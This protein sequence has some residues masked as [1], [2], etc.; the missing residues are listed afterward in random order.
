MRRKQYGDIAPVPGA[1]LLVPG[2]CGRQ[3][4]PGAQTR[5]SSAQPRHNYGVPTLGRV[6]S[7]RFFFF[8]NEGDEPP[9]VHVSEGNKLAKFWLEDGLVAKSKGFAQHELNEMQ[10]IV[11]A[12]RDEFLGEWNGFFGKA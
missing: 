1:Q 4:N 5:E 2:W 11:L 6:R 9:H 7:W 12:R 3:A 8:S 10:R